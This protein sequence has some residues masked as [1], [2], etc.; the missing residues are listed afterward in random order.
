[1]GPVCDYVQWP[2]QHIHPRGPQINEALLLLEETEEQN[3]TPLRWH[4]VTTECS[5][6]CAIVALPQSCAL[7]SST[8]G[9]KIMARDAGRC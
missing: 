1:M 5:L 3:G 7:V 4:G 2:H 9:Y 6:D 8:H